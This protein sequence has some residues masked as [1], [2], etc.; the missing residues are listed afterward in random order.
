MLDPTEAPAGIFQGPAVPQ[1]VM[2]AA[3]SPPGSHWKELAEG[4][5]SKAGVFTFKINN[6]RAK[7]TVSLVKIWKGD[8]TFTRIFP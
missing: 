2:M 8:G 5:Q 1:G 3:K 4:T 7:K 6:L